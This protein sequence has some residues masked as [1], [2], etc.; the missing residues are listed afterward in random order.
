MGKEQEKLKCAPRA[1]ATDGRLAM[2]EP[3]SRGGVASGRRDE[4]RFNTS[5]LCLILFLVQVRPNNTHYHLGQKL[6][7]Y[8]RHRRILP[9]RSLATT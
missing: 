2:G 6:F 9:T 8:R 1:D 3:D 7:S 4:F 5:P